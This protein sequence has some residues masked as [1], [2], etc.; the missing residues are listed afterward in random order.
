MF[1]LILLILLLFIFTKPNLLT[2]T[3]I[4]TSYLLHVYML[5]LILQNSRQYISKSQP[6]LSLHTYLIQP[7]S[8]SL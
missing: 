4:T 3:N 1:T 6:Y 8:L 5:D 7:I 2:P